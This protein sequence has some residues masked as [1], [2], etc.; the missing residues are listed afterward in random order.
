MKTT[1]SGCPPTSHPLLTPLLFTSTHWCSPLCVE[2]ARMQRQVSIILGVKNEE[3]RKGRLLGLCLSCSS[4]ATAPLPPPRSLVPPPIASLHWQSLRSDVEIRLDMR[5]TPLVVTTHGVAVLLLSCFLRS[6]ETEA[7]R[8]WARSP[9]SRSESVAGL[10]LNPGL[11]APSQPLAHA[12]APS[13][14]L[15]MERLCCGLSTG[16]AELQLLKK[17]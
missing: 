14:H 15:S 1:T 7:W 12:P 11:L 9:R 2:E 10:A 17:A 3:E 6:E 13:P 4:Q 5:Q 8:A 16:Q